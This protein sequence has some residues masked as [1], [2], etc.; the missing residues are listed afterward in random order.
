M[1]PQLMNSK[2]AWIGQQK[3][4]TIRDM[5][6]RKIRRTGI[7][8]SEMTKLATMRRLYCF[9]HVPAATST[10]PPATSTETSKT[11]LTMTNND[12]TT[13]SEVVT[14]ILESSK[15]G[16]ATTTSDVATTTRDPVTTME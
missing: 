14:T 11:E 10:T 1:A 13:T 6:V 2:G 3:T 4:L 15:A 7:G 8:P 9:K 16:E 12:A 5:W